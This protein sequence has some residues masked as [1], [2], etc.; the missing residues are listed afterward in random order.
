[1]L[2]DAFGG[3]PGDYQI[4]EEEGAGG[5]TFLTLLVD[6]GVDGIDEQGLLG[7]LGSELAGDNRQNRFMSRVWQN[8]GTLRI[9][10]EAPVAS[11]RGKILPLR[12]ARRG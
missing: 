8:S 9:C 5:Q 7:R 11:A 1:M 3:G 10:R 2:P 6:P 12:V 4:L